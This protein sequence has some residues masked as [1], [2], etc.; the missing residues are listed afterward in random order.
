MIRKAV[1]AL[2]LILAGAIAPARVPSDPAMVSA[3]SLL[4]AIN[5][6]R[7]N[8]A[9]F[10][11]VIDAY[12]AV[13]RRTAANKKAFDVAVAEARTRC[14]QQSALS[15]LSFDEALTKAAADHAA[16]TERS[17]LVGHIGSDKSNPGTRMQRYGR[18]TA[19]GE[20]ITYGYST[21]DMILASFIVDEH[22][23]K[24]GHRE[25]LFS[26]TYTLVGI[27]FG[28]HRTYRTTCVITL[29]RP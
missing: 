8:P 6:L 28:K 26:P 29:A 18:F 19:M 21:A 15:P 5:T 2:M 9:S 14:K 25:N 22:D 4:E 1:L 7:R 23:P 16:D 13:M 3:D 12:A 20:I 24:R 10:L 11:P 27:A 17:G